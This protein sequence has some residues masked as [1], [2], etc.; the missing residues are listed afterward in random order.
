MST[1]VRTEGITESATR[2]RARTAGFF[3][4]MTFLTSGFAMLGGGRLIV[5][6]D[7]AATA[8]NLLANESFY[9]L[10]L[11]AN[12]V[13]GAC[14]LAATLLVYELLK[15]VNWAVSL[16]AALFSLLGVAVGAVSSLFYFAPLVVQGGAGYLSV[17][18]GE[19]TQAVALLFLGLGEQAAA[20]SFGFFGV[21]CLLVGWLISRSTF[22]PRLVGSLLAF[23]GLG[24]L[25]L[26]LASLL[27]PAFARS[28]VPYISIPGV[29]GELSLTLWLLVVGVNVPRWN[30][31]AAVAFPLAR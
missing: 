7:A 5:S 26:S 14:Y 11:T 18:T 3:W 10:A 29:V 22:L 23:G 20:I 27:S 6:G 8:A 31:Q 24:W 30:E 12:L 1:A 13:A 19:Q 2:F 17:F 16:L 28:L 21:H 15:P 4:L 25:T 9:R